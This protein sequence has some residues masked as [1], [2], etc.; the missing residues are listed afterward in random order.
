MC[1]S[2][3]INVI[4]ENSI[5]TLF[6]TIEHIQDKDARRKY[7]FEL[8]NLVTRQKD[9]RSEVTPFSMKQIMERFDSKKEEPSIELLRGEVKTLK[10]EIREV[11]ARLHKIEIENLTNQLQKETTSQEKSSKAIL[12][13]ETDEEDSQTESHKF[14]SDADSGADRNCI[15]EGLIPTK[16][17]TNG[18]TKLY[19]ATAE[20][21]RGSPRLVINY[22]PLNAALKWIRYQ[23]EFKFL[24]IDLVQVAVKPLFRKGLNIPIC[25]LLRDDRL[26]NFDDSLLGVLESNLANGPVYYETVA[27][28]SPTFSDIK[29]EHKRK[30]SLG[31]LTAND[32]FFPDKR[33]LN[34]WWKLPKH[35]N[36]VD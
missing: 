31:V 33:K 22:K 17:L 20:K 34:K 10:N 25:M 14:E 26:L 27:P 12:T 21:E 8:Q 9:E 3:Y 11:K 13:E 1:D 23:K 28:D 15:I 24:H 6:S 30:E 18:T 35:Q 4:S 19:S 32:I 5:E 16:Y 29:P 7:L 2:K 36:K